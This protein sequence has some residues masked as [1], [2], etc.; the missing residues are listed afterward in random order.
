MCHPR[1]AMNTGTKT[2]HKRQTGSENGDL[3]STDGFCRCSNVWKCALKALGSLGANSYSF[4]PNTHSITEPRAVLMLSLTQNG[5]TPP[6]LAHEDNALRGRLHGVFMLPVDVQQVSGYCSRTL[7]IL[8]DDSRLRL[9]RP[10]VSKR[11]DE[12]RS[13]RSRLA[14]NR[15]RSRSH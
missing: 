12:F 1:R 4:G 15:W 8:A 14:D 11:V 6:S 5:R 13:R 3:A 10:L 7:S 2:S 9:E